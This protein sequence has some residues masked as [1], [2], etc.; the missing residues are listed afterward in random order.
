MLFRSGDAGLLAAAHE[1]DE[2]EI[3]LDATPFYAEGGGQQADWGRMSVNAPGREAELT[4]VDVQT[5]VPGLI[6]HRV[7]VLSGEARPGDIVLAQVDVDRRASV[8]RSHS[9]TVRATHSGSSSGR[10]CPA[11]VCSRRGAPQARLMA[12][13]H[14]QSIKR[15]ALLHSSS[16]GAP[17]RVRL[18]RKRRAAHHCRTAL[19]TPSGCCRCNSSQRSITT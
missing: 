6:A 4:V 3:V 2:V 17:G 9:A 15:S 19:R 18:A 8:S 16:I 10:S 5:P 12:C 11:R 1:G 14:R 7:T 13:E